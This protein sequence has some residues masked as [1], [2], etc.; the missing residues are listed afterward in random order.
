MAVKKST[1]SKFVWKAGDVT[2]DKP[3]KKSKKS[4]GSKNGKRNK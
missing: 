2:W 4:G 1:S 3:V